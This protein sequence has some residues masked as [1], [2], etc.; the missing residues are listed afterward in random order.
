MSTL[1]RT[2]RLTLRP[3]VTADTPHIV[4]G[5]G[6]FEVAKALTVVPYPYTAADANDWLHT[7]PAVPTPQGA[8]FSIDLPGVGMI[9]TMSI[10][11]ELGYWIARKYWGRGFATEAAAA[12]LAWRF[13]GLPGEIVRSS[14]HSW[15][16]ASLAVQN[17]LGF[18]ETGVSRRFVR[19]QNRDVEHIETQLTAEAFAVARQRLE[20]VGAT[21]R[22]AP[23]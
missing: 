5:L 6:D 13:A 21:G 20:A 1:L 11:R 10:A 12:L 4:A 23:P 7:V 18:V 19:A 8:V 22:E 16:R 3:Q 2:R 14:A 15:N 17:K 9:G